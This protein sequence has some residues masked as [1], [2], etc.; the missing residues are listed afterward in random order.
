MK[1]KLIRVIPKIGGEVVCARVIRLTKTRAIVKTPDQLMHTVFRKNGEPCGSFGVFKVIN[2]DIHL[3]N[4]EE[5]VRR[6]ER[7]KASGMPDHWII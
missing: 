3:L 7:N 6:Y 4:E 5:S 1:E 2:E